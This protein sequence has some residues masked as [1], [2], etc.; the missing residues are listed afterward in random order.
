MGLAQQVV[1]MF[2][3]KGEKGVQA[4]HVAPGL[5]RLPWELRAG[6]V[7]HSLN[8]LSLP[9]DCTCTWGLIIVIELF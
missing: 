7:L 1:H 9:H 4:R 5:L 2:N 6:E 3:R 8:L